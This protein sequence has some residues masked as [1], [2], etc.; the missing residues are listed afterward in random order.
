MGGNLNQITSHLISEFILEL[1]G[2]LVYTGYNRTADGHL[3]SI[4]MSRWIAD[5]LHA[6]FGEVF[7]RPTNRLVVGKRSGS[8]LHPGSV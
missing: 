5:A 6:F 4:H 3:K 2:C 7:D 8:N 1:A